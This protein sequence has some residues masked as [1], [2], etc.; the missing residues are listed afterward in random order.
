MAGQP[1]NTQDYLDVEGGKLYYEVLGQGHPLVLIHAGVADCTMWDEQIGPFSRRYR[2]I[3]YDTRG[4]G[5]TTTE[6]VAYSNRQDLYE[7]LKHFASF[8]LSAITKRDVDAYKTMKAAEGVIGPNQINKTLTRLSQILSAAEEYDLIPSNPAAGR[9]TTRAL[10][11]AAR[12]RPRWSRSH[13]R[14]P[15]CLPTW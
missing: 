5:R 1:Q 6:D 3:R 9:R 13:R 11:R 15:C 12:A 4:Y 14:G 10:R 2:V 7:L 8:R